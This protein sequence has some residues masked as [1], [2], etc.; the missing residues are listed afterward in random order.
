MGMNSEKVGG[1][2]YLKKNPKI[3]VIGT[4][5]QSENFLKVFFKNNIQ[6][7]TLCSSERSKS[8]ALILQKKFNIKFVDHNLSKI[9]KDNDFEYIF[10]LINWNKIYNK[11]VFLVK[12]TKGIIIN[13]K[14]VAVSYNAF[15]NLEKLIKLNKKK[16][17]VYVMY[18][19]RFFNTIQI[20][21]KKI[22]QNK[23]CKFQISIPEQK[24][25]LKKKYG[26][27]INGKLKY[28]I[29]SHWIDLIFYLCGILKLKN[30][31]QN[32]NLISL[33]LK[34]NYSEGIVN[35]L[36]DVKDKINF[37]FYFNDKSYVLSPLEK[38]YEISKLKKTKH[39]YVSKNKIIKDISK[40][41]L[42]PGLNDMIVSIFKKKDYHKTLPQISDLK[43]TYT[44]LQKLDH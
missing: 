9:V 7:H 44:L 30:I 29:S 36:F 3:L 20:L 33:I 26:N 39:I 35:F 32:K 12:K 40:S 21:K 22:I 34:N 6:I 16:V 19:R 15:L 10:L 25:R 13:E 31:Y 17:K 41:Y 14:P 37:H 18:N 1:N 27:E 2:I 5:T 8:K 43:P 28:F 24:M 23:R 38:L 4:G 42:K 11:L